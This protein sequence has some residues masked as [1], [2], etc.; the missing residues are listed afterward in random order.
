ME[1]IEAT[2]I[3]SSVSLGCGL[4]DACEDLYSLQVKDNLTKLG[5]LRHSKATSGC[6]AHTCGMLIRMCLTR[7]MSRTPGMCTLDSQIMR[8]HVELMCTP[9]LAR[10]EVP[11]RR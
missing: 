4:V 1:E 5:L 9:A 11:V 10:R 7:M 6:S 3:F 2:K 8:A